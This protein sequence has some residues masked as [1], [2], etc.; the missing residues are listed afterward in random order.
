MLTNEKI[1]PSSVKDA[2]KEHICIKIKYI[3]IVIKGMYYSQFTLN[4]TNS[5]RS[6]EC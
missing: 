1:N 4:D 2:F 6:N 3:Q 5:G